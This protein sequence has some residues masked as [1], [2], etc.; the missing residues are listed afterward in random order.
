[1]PASLTTQTIGSTLVTTESGTVVSIGITLPSGA[2]IKNAYGWDDALWDSEIKYSKDPADIEVLNNLKANWK[3][4]QDQ[5]VSAFNNFKQQ[6]TPSIQTTTEPIV[7][8]TQSTE[9]AQQNLQYTNTGGFDDDSGQVGTQEEANA[10]NQALADDAE[11]YGYAGSDYPPESNSEVS[12]NAGTTVAGKS[13]TPAGKAPADKP[14]RRLYNPLSKFSSYTYQISLYMVTPDAYNAFVLSGKKN[15]NAFSNIA[16]DNI[17][18]ESYN[19][20]ERAGSGVYL[21]AQSGGINNKTENR[22]PGFNLDLYIDNLEIASAVAQGK[23]EESEG[24]VNQ[25][26][27]KF[28]IT[29]PYGFSFISKLKE[30]VT[31]IVNYGSNLPD[32]Q[33][34]EFADKAI[35]VLG[36]RFLGYDAQG[37]LASNLEQVAGTTMETTSS[38]N[39]SFETY[40]DI[41]LSNIQFKLDGKAVTYNIDAIP[42]PNQE[43]YG[44]KHGRILSDT[45]A[46]GSTVETTIQ[47]LIDNLNK[48]QENIKKQRGSKIAT[49]YKVVYV[50]PD[51]DLLKLASTAN[52]IT[53]DD[54]KLYPALT[55]VET[56]NIDVSDS[57]KASPDGNQRQ[58][59]F[60]G[61]G[62]ATSIVQA[63]QLIVT[64]S[65]YITNAIKNLYPNT[66]NQKDA[67][68]DVD[69]ESQKSIKWFN[70]SVEVLNLGYDKSLRD[71]AYEITYILQPYDTPY[72]NVASVPDPTTFK[73][74]GP[75]KRYEYYLTGKNTEVM[76]FDL[77]YNNLYIQNVVGEPPEPPKKSPI[78]LAQGQRAAAPRQ[79][80]L[81][82]SMEAQN[83]YVNYLNDIGAYATA[84][85]NILGDPDFL[86]KDNA[87][88]INSIFSKYYGIDGYTINANSGQVF[89][90]IDFREAI[91]YDNEKGYMSVND[92]L[93]FFQ[94]PKIYREGKYKINGMAFQVMSINNYFRGGKF[95]QK[96]TLNANVWDVEDEEVDNTSY[97]ALENRRLNVNNNQTVG[98]ANDP[99]PSN[100]TPPQPAQEVTKPV[101]TSADDD[102]GETASQAIR[103][104]A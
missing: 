50:G 18:Q 92:K 94:Y 30:A 66:T 39:G 85:V 17:A 28:T 47:S 5:Q 88:S 70:V 96:L 104:G 69:S 58:M 32:A 51:A 74:P 100:A 10:I 48:E 20:G 34:A 8:P 44:L 71:W 36:I 65:D 59:V 77:T 79:G 15:I 12:S 87:S 75:V 35:Y 13:D 37:N 54:K 61:S 63:I 22:A 98:L 52:N 23:T 64:Q 90:E 7:P 4:I 101:N 1:M 84:Y 57:I 93:M 42:I 55:G 2:K 97:D 81:G 103:L 16:Q 9:T 78:P 72:L 89:V 99:P 41:K 19:T 49:K 38:S 46:V 91:D 24:P 27:I 33:E 73:Y 76:S 95:T 40:Y 68:K 11:I 62:G 86:V 83:E 67:N 31:E 56:P 60:K 14:G 80:K 26:V 102:A 53:N 3:S 43:G 25:S 21:I 29:E 82:K 6:T 45:S